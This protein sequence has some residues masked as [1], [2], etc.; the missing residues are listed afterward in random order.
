RSSDLERTHVA[1]AANQAPEC[2]LQAKARDEIVIAFAETRPP[3]LVQD[4]RLRPGNLVEHHKPER[5]PR[6]IDAIAQGIGAQQAGVFLGTEQIDQRTGV[7][8]VD[9]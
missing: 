9:V 5:A 4:G 8:L 7:E 1:G 2:L 6:Y 3:G